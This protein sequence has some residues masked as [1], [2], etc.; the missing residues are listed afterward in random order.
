MRTAELAERVF[1]DPAWATRLRTEAAD[2]KERFNRAFWSD[3][4][5]GFYAIGL[6]G[7]KQRIDSKTSNM[8]QLLESGIVPDDRA[9]VVVRQLMS[10]E[11]FSGW[12]VRTLAADEAGFN[13]IGYHVGTIWP[14]D[15]AII[16]SGM[17]RMGFREESNRIAVALIDAASFS[18]GR[19]PEA[20]AGFQR[21]VSRFPVPFPTA[22]SPQAWAT[23]APFA[24]V[25]AMLGLRV[26]DSEL[27][28]DPRIPEVVGHVRIR[29]IHAFGGRWDVEASGS[30]GTVTP[31]GDSGR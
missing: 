31:S 3:E 12:G 4:R 14:H 11:M 5:G 22:C 29:G 9:A 25:N 16:A 15:N 26:R 2:L 6:D 13:P 23:A 27:V 24:L 1:D 10:D 30:E 21:D 20:F 19:L 18:R 8:G 7:D 28:M 17:A